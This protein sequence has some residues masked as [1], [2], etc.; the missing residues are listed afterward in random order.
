MSFIQSKDQ[1][2]QTLVL[3]LKPRKLAIIYLTPTN[4]T[5]DLNMLLTSKRFHNTPKPILT[6]RNVLN[7]YD[8]I[9]VIYAIEY[10]S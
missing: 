3:L 10:S 2:D 4:Y 6:I 9:T 1:N 7:Y 5:T 8:I